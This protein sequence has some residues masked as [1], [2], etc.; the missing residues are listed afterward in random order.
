M[1]STTSAIQHLSLVAFGLSLDFGHAL[2]DP[3]PLTLIAA[4]NQQ[5]PGYDTGIT[6]THFDQPRITLFASQPTLTFW[7][8]VAGPGIDATNNAVIFGNRGGSLTPIYATGSVAPWYTATTFNALFNLATNSSGQIALG[9]VVA[10]TGLPPNSSLEAKNAGVFVE[11]SP[12]TLVPLAREGEP[13]VPFPSIIWNNMSAPSITDGGT[14]SFWSGTPGVIWSASVG[15]GGGGGGASSPEPLYIPGITLPG[16]VPSEIINH[17]SPHTLGPD[18]Q[19]AFHTQI[20]EVDPRFPTRAALW[21]DRDGNGSALPLALAGTPAPDGVSLYSRPASRA[22]INIHGD[23]VFHALLDASGVKRQ[24]LIFDSASSQSI[25]ARQGDPCTALPGEVTFNTLSTLPAI[26]ACGSIAFH[27]TLAGS[28]TDPSN[29]GAIF[30]STSDGSLT[31][32]LREGDSIADLPGYVITALADPLL[33]DSGAVVVM[34]HAVDATVAN[35]GRQALLA[36]TPT[37]DVRLITSVGQTI[38]IAPGDTR[39]IQSILWS[40]D[41]VGAGHA[42]T[43]AGGQI[44]L[45]LHLSGDTHALVTTILPSPADLNADG[46]IDIIDF[47]DFMDAFSFCEN[48]PAPCS[49]L[50]LDLD[51]SGTID[52]LDFLRFFQLFGGGC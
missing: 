28:S 10:D 46:Q 44:A 6:F 4:S 14:V 48:Q 20:T 18:G 21:L 1:R 25:V 34:A 12:G 26:N 52:I 3:L 17:L 45:V 24:T 23:T 39:T 15:G 13:T 38:D 9:A 33:L 8:R 51:G 47:L 43:D 35:S 49:D 7:A 2:A 16:L 19:I 22:A 40:T 41:P 37:G 32:L 29:N 5:A 50:N 36:V 11:S 30:L 27:A 42:Q 31:S